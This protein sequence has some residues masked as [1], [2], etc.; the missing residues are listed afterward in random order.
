MQSCT[1]QCSQ[2]GLWR[3]KNESAA[4]KCLLNDITVSYGLGAAVAPQDGVIALLNYEWAHHIVFL[5]LEDVAVP[6]V[7]VPAGPRAQRISHG[8]GSV[9]RVNCMITVVIS[10]GFMRTV[11]FHP[12]SLAS[13]GIGLSDA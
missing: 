12:I 10:P 2:S 8:A 4:Q 3:C 9:G 11:S 13:G 5:M 1:A 7:F 6:H